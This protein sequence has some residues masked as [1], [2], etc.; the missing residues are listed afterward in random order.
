MSIFIDGVV[1]APPLLPA[2]SEYELEETVMLPVVSVLTVGVKVAVLK[3]P[4]VVSEDKLPPLTVTSSE[5]NVVPGSSLNVKVMV[6]D[7]P[8]LRLEELLVIDKVGAIESTVVM[9]LLVDA[10]LALPA[11]SITFALK[12]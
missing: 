6:A 8:E 12:A 1:P 11:A 2:A 3:A 7:W 10:L 9:K 5:V 4:D